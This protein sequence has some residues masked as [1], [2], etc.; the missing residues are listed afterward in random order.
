MKCKNCGHKNKRNAQF[1]VDCGAPLD[2]SGKPKNKSILLLLAIIIILILIIGF[3]VVSGSFNNNAP[4]GNE[5]NN[6]TNNN[7][8]DADAVNNTNDSDVDVNNTKEVSNE[9]EKQATI[10]KNT[11]KTINDEKYEV[12]EIY[13]VP[14]TV[15]EG[16]SF[17]SACTYQFK[18]NGQECEVEEVEHYETSDSQRTIEPLKFSKDYPGGEGY[19]LTVNNHVWKGIKVEK[20]NRWYHISMKTNNDDEAMKMLD[21]MYKKNTWVDH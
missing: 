9:E 2:G 10:L 18:F 17:R 13:G 20:S 19:V 16:G 8:S 1:C 12:I 11:P 5:V 7:T 3:F 21:W 14:F 4:I 15:P 6:T